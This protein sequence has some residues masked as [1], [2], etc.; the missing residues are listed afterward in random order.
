MTSTE[1]AAS[2]PARV[3]EL[4]LVATAAAVD[5]RDLVRALERAVPDGVA[6]RAVPGLLAP[7]G[8]GR[9]ARDGARARGASVVVLAPG[10]PDL[11]NHALLSVEAARA[12]G[13]AVAAVVVAGP[14]GAEQRAVLREHAGADVVELADLQAPS[15]AVA[16][17]PLAAWAE[18]EPILAAGAGAARVALAPYG[19]WEPRVAPDPRSAGRGA[20]DPVMLEIVAAEGPVLASRAYGLYNRAAGGRKL[21]TIARAPLSSAAYR[22]RAEGRVEIATSAQAGEQGEDVLRLAGTP[23]VRVRELGPRALD[24][25]PLEEVAEL[26]RRLRTAGAADLPRAVLDTYGLVRMTTKAEEY[27]GRAARLADH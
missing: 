3:P 2:Y 9:L 15:A 25:V 23:A 20:I 1:S 11:A 6:V 27:L 26:M 4:L 19:G 17:W 22:L 5:T 10:G 18:A 8:D 24:E 12:V 16:T 21:T 13:L 7:T 14:G